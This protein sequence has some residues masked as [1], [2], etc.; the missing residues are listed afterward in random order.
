[1]EVIIGDRHAQVELVSKEGNK[2]KISID[3]KVHDLDVVMAENGVCSIINE[4]N[5]YNAE[6]LRSDNGK[7]YKVNV[8]LSSYDLEMVDERDKL[9]R[10]RKKNGDLNFSNQLMTPMP[11]KIVSVMVQ[12]GDEVTEGTPLLTIEAMKMQSVYKATRDCV[13]RSVLVKEKDTVN[14]NPVLMILE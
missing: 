14:S 4:G 5:S 11:G 6:L 2:V 1:M 10:S 13:V 8:N 3:G 7:K 9:M 12:D